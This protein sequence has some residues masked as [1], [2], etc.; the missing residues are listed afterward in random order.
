[1]NILRGFLEFTLGPKRYHMRIGGSSASTRPPLTFD[2]DGVRSV[3]EAERM[4]MSL[5]AELD[6]LRGEARLITGIPDDD[7]DS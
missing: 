4:Q 6:V 3:D 1:M 7:D 2:V 5:L